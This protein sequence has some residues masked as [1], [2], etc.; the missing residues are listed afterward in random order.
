MTLLAAFAAQVASRPGQPALI[1]GDGHELTYA[2]LDGWSAALAKQYERAGVGRGTRVV[3]ALGI[4]CELYAAL[5]ALWRLGAVAVFPEPAAG[6]RGLRHALRATHPDFLIGTRKIALLCALVA[7]RL[8]LARPLP[9][10]FATARGDE[11]TPLPETSP[12]LITFTSGSTGPPKGIV[13][14]HGFLSAQQRALTTLLQPPRPTR[15]LVCLPMFVLAGLSL[16]V[17][18]ALPRFDIR[19]RH[20]GLG[21]ALALQIRE[22]R[23]TRL[24]A[25]PSIVVAADQAGV[26]SQLEHILTG[27]GPVWPGLMRQLLEKA[28]DTN[29]TLVYGST[30]AEPIA[31]LTLR[32]VGPEDWTQMAS[33]GGLLAGI[34]VPEVRLRIRDHEI[35][36]AGV[37]VNQ[38]YLNPDDDLGNKVREGSCIWHRTGDAGRLDERGRLW[39]L[40]RLEGRAHDWY[41]FQVEVA[42]RSWPGVK[43]AA[44][45]D[46]DGQPH[47]VVAGDKEHAPEWRLG[48]RHF[49]G[50]TLA[51]VEAIPLDLR[52]HAK[53]DYGRLRA[54][55]RSRR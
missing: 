53:V 23:L 5:I 48:M 15:D 47:L 26:I 52:H 33:G 16:G 41:P 7:Q 46:M 49:A 42:A 3:V 4:S 44:L 36:V 21:A 55:L 50:L 1:D 43:D 35:Q 40:G 27:G 38:G 24:L 25:S 8:A 37:H 6:I 51:V 31:H 54:L 28:P 39:L 11:P 19:R 20:A 34:P 2:A 18:S 32:D 13:R 45:V 14:S 9:V 29:V 10:A 17:T 12:A 30:E 22:Q